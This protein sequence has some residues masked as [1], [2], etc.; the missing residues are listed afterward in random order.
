MS[1]LNPATATREGEARLAVTAH[2]A[3]AAQA[4]RAAAYGVASERSRGDVAAATQGGTGP[5]AG[6]EVASWSPD[7]ATVKVG[8]AASA[9]A[10]AGSRADR[11]AADRATEAARDAR[12]EIRSKDGPGLQAQ[13]A[14]LPHGLVELLL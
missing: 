8:Q 13:A 4:R 10:V 1:T 12:L 2:A 7:A 6:A 5:G 11:I 9:L 3:R 14:Q